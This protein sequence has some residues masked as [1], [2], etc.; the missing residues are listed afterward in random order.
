MSKELIEEAMALAALLDR[1][2]EEVRDAGVMAIPLRR[3]GSEYATDA[4]A[5]LDKENP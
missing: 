2:R 1:D 4:L 3:W 5:M